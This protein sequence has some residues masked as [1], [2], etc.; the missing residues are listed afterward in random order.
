MEIELLTHY[1][2]YLFLLQYPH[3]FLILCEIGGW[4]RLFLC[5]KYFAEMVDFT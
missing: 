1:V 3:I 2:N 5:E 4:V